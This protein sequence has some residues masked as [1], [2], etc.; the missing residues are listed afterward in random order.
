MFKHTR[1]T[2]K[3][4]LSK[5]NNNQGSKIDVKNKCLKSSSVQMCFMI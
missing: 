5:Y 2:F 3:I 4:K 1:R